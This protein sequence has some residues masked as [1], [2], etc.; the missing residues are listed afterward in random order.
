MI[1]TIG[2][3]LENADTDNSRIKLIFKSVFIFSIIAHLYRYANTAFNSD[4]LGIDRGG[5]DVP[6]QI[7]RGRWLQPVYLKIRGGIGAPFLIGI[8]ATLYLAVSI[9]LMT[10]I[11][12]ITNQKTIIC[13]CGLLSAAPAIT[14]TNAAFIPW[15]DIFMLSLLFSMISTYFLTIAAGKYRYLTAALFLILSLAL[16]QSYIGAC[17]LICLFWL[18]R[19]CIENDRIKEI[20]KSA[21]KIIL[22]F[23]A[24]LGLYYCSCRAVCAI[25]SIGQLNSYN[26]VTNA[27]VLSSPLRLPIFI[28][29]A[30][31]NVLRFI[32]KPEIFHSTVAGGI[33][34]L[35]LL[36]AVFLLYAFLKAIDTRRKIF[37]TL[38]L[39][40]CPLASY[41]IYLL[42]GHND[43]LLTFPISM[44]YVGVGMI[45][46]L[47]PQD[48]NKRL[49]RSIS[50]VTL[51][52]AC[53][54][55]FLGNVYSNQVY[56]K[57]AVES[58]QTLSLMT[59][60]LYH[61]EQ[62]EGYVPGETPVALIGTLQDSDTIMDKPAMTK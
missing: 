17:M 15:T 51:L 40:L 21:S 22:V 33:N 16:Y 13:L 36:I 7:G 31:L 46:E 26:S 39:M 30:Y 58:Q 4:S 25:F 28:I 49:L 14:I 5:V 41:F 56:V 57:K 10:E 24:S 55:I 50:K 32:L 59:R 18:I 47:A 48:M 3:F 29:K 62:T 8:L 27:T 12:T 42:Y 11:L 19:K 43:T 52:A 2:L 35:L 61:M 20:I 1:K 37:I 23:I 6:K 60:V 45:F 53:I 44:L 34:V 54:L 9:V 38:L